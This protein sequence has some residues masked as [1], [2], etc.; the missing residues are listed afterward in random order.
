MF[1]DEFGAFGRI[2]GELAGLTASFQTICKKILTAITYNVEWF[3]II[4]YNYKCHV[5]Y[6]DI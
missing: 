4:Y 6:C 1:S 3:S 2:V 5:V